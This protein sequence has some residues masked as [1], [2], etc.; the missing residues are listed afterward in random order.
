MPG[1]PF[2][3]INLTGSLHVSGSSYHTAIQT[4]APSD[5]LFKSW[6]ILYKQE[7]YSHKG[8]KETIMNI[9]DNNLPMCAEKRFRATQ[10]PSQTTYFYFSSRTNICLDLCL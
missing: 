2:N 1:V 3:G 8:E 5:L 10:K 7:A 6:H 9:A 4:M